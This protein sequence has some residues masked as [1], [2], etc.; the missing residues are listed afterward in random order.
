MSK[1]IIKELNK[2]GETVSYSSFIIEDGVV[3]VNP[4]HGFEKEKVGTVDDNGDIILELKP[5]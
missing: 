3:Y 1:L 2:D 4:I 5:I